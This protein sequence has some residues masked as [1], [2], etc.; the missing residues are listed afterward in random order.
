MEA[1]ADDQGGM[2]LDQAKEA[3]TGGDLSL[4]QVADSILA[5]VAKFFGECISSPDFCALGVD[6][7]RDSTGKLLYL[8][9]VPCDEVG[10]EPARRWPKE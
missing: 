4:D 6:E 1:H 9:L 3:I 5:R 8:R 7:K 10:G 2:T